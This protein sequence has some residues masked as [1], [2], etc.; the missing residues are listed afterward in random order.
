[1]EIFSK[2]P[3]ASSPEVSLDGAGTSPLVIAER[4]STPLP[5]YVLPVPGELLGPCEGLAAFCTVIPCPTVHNTAAVVLNALNS[6]MPSGFM[7]Q[8]LRIH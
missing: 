4:A 6:Y 3:T 1:M 7:G 2:F 8:S 5:V